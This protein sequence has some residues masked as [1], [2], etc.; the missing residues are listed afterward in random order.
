VVGAGLRA[1]PDTS[2]WIAALRSADCREVE[3]LRSLLDD[4]RVAL[5]AP[6]R[7]EIL[8]GA[9][10]PDQDRLRP[11]LAALPNWMP[12][13]STWALIETWLA[14]AARVGQRFGMGDLLIAAIAAEHKAPI[15][16]LD[17]GFE[18][19]AQMDWLELHQP[20]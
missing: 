11:L 4:D 7:I 15:W 13:R 9:S 8:S 6:V 3:H 20:L 5:A 19:M 1:R 12:E 10:A 2:V 14:S 16:T 17:T 18:R